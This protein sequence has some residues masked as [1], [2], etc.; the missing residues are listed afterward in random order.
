[1]AKLSHRIFAI[2]MAAVFT[3]SV[4]AFSAIVVYD[5]SQSRKN[6]PADA[7]AAQAQAQAQAQQTKQEAACP[8]SPAGATLPV[9]ESYIAPAAVTTLEMADLEPGDG[10]G[11]KNGDCLT[12]KYYGALASNG[13]VFDENFTKETAI[14]FQLGQGRVIKGWE[15]GLVGMKVNGTRRLVIPATQ[16]YADQSPSEAIPANSDLVFFVKLLEIK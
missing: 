9:P 10:A 3:I 1:M 7:A 16:A 5:I 8:S 4:V 6:R 14:G 15:E 12:V 13:N 11:A 2:T